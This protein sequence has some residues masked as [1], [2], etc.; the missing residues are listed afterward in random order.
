[1]A[2][3]CIKMQISIC[4][5]FY[6][7]TLKTFVLVTQHEECSVVLDTPLYTT[8]MYNDVYTAVMY[9]PLYIT[10][11]HHS[12]RCWSYETITSFFTMHNVIG[13]NIDLYLTYSQT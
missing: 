7:Q 8:V 11:R 3:T 1:M 5:I 4:P 13:A 2:T 6:N 10:V 12:H 9:I